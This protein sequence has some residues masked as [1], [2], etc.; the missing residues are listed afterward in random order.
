MTRIIAGAAKGRRLAVPTSGTRPTSDRV[1]ESLFSSLD[2]L[3]PFDR[4]LDLYA[5][6]GALGLE[7]VSRW[8]AHATFVESDRRSADVIRRNAAAIGS[9]PRA[10]VVVSTVQRWLDTALAVPFAL[11][12]IDPPYLLS[13]D[14]LGRALYALAQG[15]LQPEALVVVERSARSPQPAWPD[16]VVPYRM[17]RYG[18]TA[19]WYGRADTDMEETP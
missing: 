10:D 17:K 19:L 2:A 13:D 1:R 14:E 4:V 8:G 6:S 15:W 7:A 12:L 16:S 3:G 11:V 18:D 9:A 5:G